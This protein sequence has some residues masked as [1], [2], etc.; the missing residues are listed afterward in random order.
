MRAAQVAKPPRLTS[1]RAESRCG[2]KLP[3]K[4]DS[5]RS[6][7]CVGGSVD[8]AT[9]LPFDV[10]ER[11]VADVLAVD[12]V[13]D[14]FADV[15]GVIA[16]AL[17]RT[18]YPHDIERPADG[19]RVLHHEGDALTLDGLVLFVDQPVLAGDPQ[20][21]LHI[22]AGKG[23]ERRVHHVRH[24][25]PEML[26]LAVLV[27]RTL[28]G[29]EAR[30]DVADFL[31]LIADALEVGDGLDDGDDDP[32]IAGGRCARGED[33]AAL[34]IDGDFHVVHLEVIHRD[35]LAEGAIAFD[36]R[37]NRLV[38]LL[39]DEA[40][41]AEHFAA[42]PLEVLVEA[43]RNVV[44]EIGGF[45]Q[46]AS[47]APL[48]CRRVA[49]RAM[50]AE[51]RLTASLARSGNGMGA[52][53]LKNWLVAVC[54]LKPSAARTQAARSSCSAAAMARFRSACSTP[55]TPGSMTSSG[56][57]T[58]KAATGT[59]QASASIMT[60]PKVSVRLGNTRTS[61]PERSAASSAPKR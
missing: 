18:H 58:G 39:L 61:A 3:V 40:A 48:V 35:L 59:P 26:D 56:P 34:I 23:V 9:Q 8:A 25:A 31:G 27:R 54:Q 47:P 21:R 30:G 60:S 5:G 36:Q 24:H 32:Q 52:S 15:L 7:G 1:R 19:A 37:S 53:P 51:L 46:F 45:H 55:V 49:M 20:R 57:G 2:E 22:H 50:I 44:T 42:N 33:A 13:D 6:R 10:I 29:G 41:H 12:H 43:A 17:E 28:H 4:A 11:G 16:D 38:Q 14:V